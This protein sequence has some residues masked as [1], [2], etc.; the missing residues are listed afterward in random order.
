MAEG[1][2]DTWFSGWVKAAKDKSGE[3]FD[4]MKRDLTEFSTVVQKDTATAVASTAST[5]KGKLHE[6][7]ISLPSELG[8]QSATGGAIKEG[9]SN[10]LGAIS[11]SLAVDDDDVEEIRIGPA[12]PTAVYGRAQARLHNMQIDPGT[13]CN[14]PDGP[15][16]LYIKWLETFDLEGIKGDISDLLVA[17]N[18]VRALYTRLVPSAVSH[19][20]FWQRYFYKLHQL[21]QDEARRA[22]LME[23]ADNTSPSDDLGWED[24]EDEWG[25][26]TPD[27]STLPAISEGAIATQQGQ[28]E[29]QN[30]ESAPREAELVIPEEEQSSS[31]V[32]SEG[33][34]E[35]VM[36]EKP[37]SEASV[38]S[39]EASTVH[40]EESAKRSSPVSSDSSDVVLVDRPDIEDT[41]ETESAKTE[42]QVQQTS[43]AEKSDKA[44]AVQVSTVTQESLDKEDSED[45]T[46]IAERTEPKQQQSLDTVGSD[47]VVEANA[48][49]TIVDS[50][51]VQVEAQ[52][53]IPT[54]KV[55][56]K[57]PEA[58][59]QVPAAESKKEDVK[60]V[61]E[62]LAETKTVEMDRASPASAG[63]SSGAKDSSESL[64]DDWEKDFDLDLTEEEMRIAQA[65]LEK[66]GKDTGDLDDDWESWE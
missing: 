27:A 51:A 37:S 19:S 45:K 4:F 49:E 22:A 3:V 32:S 13:Y 24:D 18:E 42:V 30:E 58:E 44:P 12:S 52:V 48:E 64:S 54:E 11:R 23:R 10:F 7:K 55:E 38:S 66:D 29:E 50:L 14:E 46:G 39:D 62:L 63:G 8:E 41:R 56:E 59:P 1:G 15:Q 36:L 31:A 9:L 35:L 57:G 33:S 26:E 53:R 60:E 6:R 16:D 28:K 43:L 5:V 47:Q 34:S 2:G 25:W 40:V 61:H 17:K 65:A 21:Q 20:E